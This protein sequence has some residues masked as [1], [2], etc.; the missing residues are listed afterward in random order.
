[1]IA[2]A[3]PVQS[4]IRL[5]SSSI[6]YAGLGFAADLTA[7]AQVVLA[8]LGSVPDWVQQACASPKQTQANWA[9][10]VTIDI[11][12]HNIFDSVFFEHVQTELLEGPKGRITQIALIAAS[13]SRHLGGWI[14]AVIHVGILTASKLG[15]TLFEKL[16]FFDDALDPTSQVEL[17]TP[18]EGL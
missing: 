14:L 18:C 1:M 7:H 5:S 11:Q 2:P 4:N 9:M 10:C 15:D 6:L 12:P 13:R 3:A 16:R 8:Y 17:S